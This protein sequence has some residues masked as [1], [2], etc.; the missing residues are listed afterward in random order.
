MNILESVLIEG[1]WGDKT[2]SI[3]LHDDINFLIGINGS[4]KTTLIN[5]IAAA[6]T[7]DFST[8]DKIA[9]SSLQLQLKEV[10]GRKKPSVTI[11]KKAREQSPF[12]EIEY[13]IRDSVKD[14]PKKYSLDDFEE[15]M[16]YREYSSS[17][18]R[19]EMLRR[20]KLNRSQSILEHLQNLVRS[21]WLSVHRSPS[22]I[23]QERR[24]VGSTVDQKLDEL[25]N[26]LVRYFSALGKKGASQLE[27][28]QETVFLSLLVSENQNRLF[29]IEAL[30]NIDEEKKL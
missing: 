6:L 15:Q 14:S 17:I 4:G 8:L 5:L 11:T 3:D 16:L 12:P 23:E 20:R 2:L 19:H 1:F 30:D 29:N 24:P 22:L 21:S 7:A 10:R 18:A 13:Q 27:K 9:F 28:F 26:R 25:S